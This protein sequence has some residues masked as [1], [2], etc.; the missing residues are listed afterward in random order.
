M[1]ASPSS[2]FFSVLLALIGL[3]SHGVAGGHPGAGDVTD[4]RVARDTS[5]DNWLVKGGTFAQTEFSPLAQVTAAN[6]DRL[7]LAWLAELD[8]PMGLTAEPLVIDGV[9]Y[10]SAPG[11]IVYAI[12]G[13][14]GKMIWRFDPHSRL[15]L[16]I[17]GS[18]DSR[19]NR[20]VAVW[21]GRVYVGTGDGRLVAI[22][23]ATGN[24]LWAARVCDPEQSG[25]TGAP[26]VARGKVF[27]GYSG[28]DSHVRGSIAAFDAGTGK[29][30]WRFWTVPGD[31][32]KGYE[33]KTVETAA[34]SWSG[35]QWW[36][37]GGGTVW[38]PITFDPTTGLLLFGTS[39]AFLADTSTG[40]TMLPGAKLFSGSI[41]AVHA[42][43]GEYAW[44]YQTSTPQ[45]QTENF[46]I[47]LADITV[48]GRMR[49]VA[50]SAARN[51]TFYVLDAAT[52]E[53]L[54]ATPL[55]E[56]GLPRSLT[57]WGADQ[58]DY[59]GVVL[60]GVEDCA[61]GCFGVRNWWPMSYNPVTQLVYVPIMDKRRTAQIP[62]TLPMVGR[63]V[64]WDPRARTTR[65][66]VEHPIIVNGG[67]LSTAGNL[68]FQGQGSGEFAAY[69]ADS[70]KKLWSLE[71]GSAI[72]SVPVT[73][74]LGNE[75]YVIV[76]IGWGSVF[77]LFATATM[78]ATAQS[79]YGPA[80]LLAFKLG[81]RLP[82]PFPRISIPQVPRPPAQTYSAEAVKRGELAAGEFGCTGCHSPRL[83]GSGRWIVD[84]GVPDL[85]YM[86]AEAHRD[87][88]AIV[89]GGTHSRQGMLSFSA[90]RAIPPTPAMTQ[91]QA[92]DIHAYVIARA[93]AAYDA[94]RS[95]AAR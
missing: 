63:L 44:H 20:G 95:A 65:W 55:V 69:A 47:L 88:Y 90:A 35:P 1:P 58:L 17:E 89:L 42:D 79:R 56:Q 30:L 31:P 81:A 39:K 46:H 82:Y 78:T 76:P 11:S 12:D 8:S 72:S 38:D 84:G 52:G 74:R 92:D 3:A 13:A 41:V 54:S 19:T 36:K 80:R 83:D 86:P 64:A 40:Q 4:E 71:T 23:A 9:I 33:S 87:W 59:P 24:Q 62:G 66:S 93:W 37:Q 22:D 94:Q 6:V 51:G 7:G 85:R 73:Y 75:Q 91:A 50:M 18:G 67:V 5:G 48:G 43:T 77:R 45:R 60:G 2:R 34:R 10:L 53:L 29:E 32:A 16:S 27:M 15:D 70:G 68:V 21:A 57:G 49:H 25:I 61:E 26:R 28:A 14:S